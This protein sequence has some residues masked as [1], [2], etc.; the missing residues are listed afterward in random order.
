VAAHQS[1]EY[2]LSRIGR[3]LPAFLRS[4]PITQDL[5]FL[6]DLAT[7]EWGVAQAFH[8]PWR[9]PL[10]PR[11]L[12]G[13]SLDDWARATLGFQPSMRVLTSAWP[14]WDLWQ[15]RT[16]PRD[17]I[18]IEL[19]DRPQ[20][21]LVFRQ[22]RQVRCVLIDAA[23]AALLEALQRGAPL[24]P[25]CQALAG[26]ATAALLQGWFERWGQ[27]GLIVSCEPRPAASPER[28]GGP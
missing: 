8:A 26:E 13:W 15:A 9:T 1:H 5:P 3:H 16:Q 2:N 11:A 19:I 20:R 7:L 10:D 22:E 25:A 28:P 14:I 4:A 17:T 18:T 6:P 21:V 24:G 27:E 23:P 12:A